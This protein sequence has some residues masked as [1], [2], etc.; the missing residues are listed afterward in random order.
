M[1]VF[2]PQFFH[3]LKMNVMELN[4]K[5]LSFTSMRAFWFWPHIL[6][7]SATTTQVIIL[8]STE[9]KTDT[10][11]TIPKNYISIPEKCDLLHHAARPDDKIYNKAWRTS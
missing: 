11:K 5:G 6:C 3:L 8:L 2:L 1:S 10:T 7:H 4:V 9:R